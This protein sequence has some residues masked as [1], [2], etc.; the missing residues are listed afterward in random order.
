MRCAEVCMCVNGKE[1]ERKLI[2]VFASRRERARWKLQRATGACMRQM[3]DWNGT[4]TFQHFHTFLQLKSFWRQF[5]AKQIAVQQHQQQQ[6]NHNNQPQQQQLQANKQ[7]NWFFIGWP[8]IAAEGEGQAKQLKK[9][10]NHR[11]PNPQMHKPTR[12]WCFCCG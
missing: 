10:E 11:N 7:T 2:A 4:Y 3:P 12:L 5:C 8:T 6:Q 9:K 1:I